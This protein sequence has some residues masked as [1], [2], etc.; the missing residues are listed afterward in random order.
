[1]PGAPSSF[2]FLLVRH[3]LLEAMQLLLGD[4]ACMDPKKHDI[5]NQANCR[6]GLP[7]YRFST[8]ALAFQ[9]AEQHV[10]FFA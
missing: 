10:S 7:F 5:W 6:S 4:F 9:R 3:L 8:G 1:M 2:L